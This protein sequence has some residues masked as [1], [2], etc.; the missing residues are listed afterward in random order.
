MID[1]NLIRELITAAD[2]ARSRSYA[3]YSDYAVGAA[4]LTG[5]GRIITGCNMEN[6]AF[7][8]G[9][10]AERCAVYKAVSEGCREFTA[11]A[12]AGSPV[13]EPIS[14]FASPCGVCRQVMREFCDD[15][16]K[17]ILLTE[18]TGGENKYE[19]YDLTEV[20]PLSFGPTDMHIKPRR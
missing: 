5:D 8:P 20:L 12:V 19:V 3:P 17:V 14:Q 15:D 18:Q 2:E 1:E 16:F 4:L 11:I 13:G 10:C 9:I 6:A 7:G